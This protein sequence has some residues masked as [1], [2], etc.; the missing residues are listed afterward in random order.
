MRLFFVGGPRG[1][2]PPPPPSPPRLRRVRAF[3]FAGISVLQHLLRRCEHL[4]EDHPQCGWAGQVQDTLQA[5][6][7]LRD[8]RDAG[9]LSAHGLAT[10]RGR[11]LARLSRLID[12]PPALDDAERFAAH[13][14]SEFP[15]IFTFLWDPS[16]DATNW[17]A[18]QAIRP[19]VVIRKVCGGNRTRKGAD[20][21]QV[22]ASVVRTARQRNI[23]L[24]ALFATMLRAPDAI[25]PDAFGLPPPPASSAA[26]ARAH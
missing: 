10:A 22:L 12:N 1:F 16:V 21:Q 23:D 6:L 14:A 24:P 3:T 11:L 2:W 17:R 4:L 15:A 7:A 13:L 8:R 9:S 20:T 26:P 19:A 5:G 25:V 18:E